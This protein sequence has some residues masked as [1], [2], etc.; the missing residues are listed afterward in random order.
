[1]NHSI[2]VFGEKCHRFPNIPQKNEIRMKFVALI[3]QSI[4]CADKNP[5]KAKLIALKIRQNN[6]YAEQNWAAM[7]VQKD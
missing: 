2:T 3:E 5:K 4:D 7:L 6:D 1:M